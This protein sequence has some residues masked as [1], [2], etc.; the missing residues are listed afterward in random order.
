MAAVTRNGK[1]LDDIL[2]ATERTGGAVCA[3]CRGSAKTAAQPPT[4]VPVA[5]VVRQGVPISAEA[6]T[7]SNDR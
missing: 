6:G 2:K 3:E 1:V 4:P 7:R 5:D